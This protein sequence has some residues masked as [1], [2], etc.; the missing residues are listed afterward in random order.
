[1]A[2]PSVNQGNMQTFGSHSRPLVYAM[3]LGKAQ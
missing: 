1:M 2:T 3:N